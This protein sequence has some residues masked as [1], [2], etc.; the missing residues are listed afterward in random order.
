MKKN[1]I[2]VIILTLIIF[3]TSISKEPTDLKFIEMEVLRNGDV[4]GFSNYKFSKE[5]DFLK[6]DNETK[7]K[8]D[9]LGV[10][11]LKHDHSPSLYGLLSLVHEVPEV[12]E[13]I[14]H[15]NEDIYLKVL[16]LIDYC[17]VDGYL[18][19][20]SHAPIDSKLIVLVAHV[21]GVDGFQ[22]S[23]TRDNLMDKVNLLIESEESLK[24]ILDMINERFVEKVRDGSIYD[25]MNE[26]QVKEFYGFCAD[27]AWQTNPIAAVMWNRYL[28]YTKDPIFSTLPRV[29]YVHGHT[30]EWDET[31]RESIRHIAS[32]IHNLDDGNNLGKSPEHSIG[33]LRFLSGKTGWIKMLE[34]GQ[35]QRIQYLHDDMDLAGPSASPL[36]VPSTS[37]LAGNP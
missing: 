27:D 24:Q 9:L 2:T 4:I 14:H 22:D 1:F 18:H 37:P 34:T 21:L 17:E 31:K 13:D 11:F 5:N 10:N 23:I 28:N 19:I 16:K 33:Q 30:G 20:L 36:A 35:L 3:K 8:V 32:R 7:F 25:W 15:F 29:D 12:E 26:S 6:V